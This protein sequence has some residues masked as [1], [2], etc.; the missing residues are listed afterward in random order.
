M[1]IESVMPSNHLIFCWPLLL[2]SMIPSMRVFSDES[3]LCIRWPKYW[4]DGFCISP[5]SEYSRLISFR[6]LRN[7]HP[8][9]TLK[10]RRNL[11]AVECGDYFVLLQ[12]GLK[13]MFDKTLLRSQSAAS[14][15]EG[16]WACAAVSI[17]QSLSA[18]VHST[19]PN[20]MFKSNQRPKRNIWFCS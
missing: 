1:S 4:S 8:W 2:L 11:R 13:S 5:S 16:P 15:T 12:K 18:P 10:S 20:A 19:P 14:R 7:Y 3:V 17:L 6:V 9:D